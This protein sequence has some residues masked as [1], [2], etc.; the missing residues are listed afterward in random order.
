[1]KREKILITGGAGYLGSV[2]VQKLMEAKKT[3]S[4]A[5]YTN[6][7]GDGLASKGSMSPKKYTWEKVTVLDN[8]MYKQTPLTNY[9]YRGDFEF[10]AGDVRDEETLLPLVQEADVIIPLA[11]IVG[12]PACE[13]NKE[14]ATAVNYEHVKFIAENKRPDTKLIYPNTNSGYGVGEKGIFC[15]EET[16]MN[17]I[18]HYGKTKSSA[19]KHV[20]DNGGVALR[21]ATVFGVSPR[22]RLDLLLND[23]TYK[24]YKDG[25][26]V[27]F[28]SG[29]SRNFIHVQDVALTFIKAIVDYDIM[30]GKAYNAGNTSCNM[31][32]LQLAE[33]I[34]NHFPKF[35]IYCDELQED[36]DKR[37]YLVSNAKLEKLNWKCH[38]S[39]DDGIRELRKSFE[40]LGNHL[41]EFTNL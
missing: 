23:F 21:L 5:S 37:D 15:T 7:S 34:K 28:E 31:S 38:Y 32:K 4:S 10:I 11:A 30:G 41:T 40:I 29:F 19:E 33:T 24:A 1:M 14:L 13:K 26:I 8:L 22:M 39:V 3:W 16:P 2:L 12:F 17:P 27:L 36:P 35:A 20:V 25:Y 6:L 18:S 9:C